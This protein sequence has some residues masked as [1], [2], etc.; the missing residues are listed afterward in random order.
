MSAGFHVCES[1]KIS[2]VNSAVGR[3]L[4]RIARD[5][6]FKSRL[7]LGF[8]TPVT[9]AYIHI[10]FNV[11][12]QENNGNIHIHSFVNSFLFCRM[13]ECFSVSKI[14][15]LLAHTIVSQDFKEKARV[16]N[17]C[18]FNS[19]GRAFEISFIQLKNVMLL[20]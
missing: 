5:P 11:Y 18:T 12:I 4:A 19:A 17:F 20:L 10:V 16:G 8:S 15:T 2:G 6:E 7:R 9:P 14:I 3:L 1:V 13:S